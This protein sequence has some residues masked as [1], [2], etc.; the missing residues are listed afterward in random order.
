[1]L[2]EDD[3]NAAYR[4][5]FEHD[6]DDY[7]EM[8][9]QEAFHNFMNSMPGDGGPQYDEDLGQAHFMMRM[10]G[11]AAV[12]RGQTAQARAVVANAVPVPVPPV[13]N[14]FPGQGAQ[15]GQGQPAPVP[16]CVNPAPPRVNPPPV[17]PVPRINQRLNPCNGGNA[18]RGRARAARG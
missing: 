3:L 17:V 4:L 7:T 9:M 1:M 10:R 14:P 13:P 8:V 15:L 2:L 16:P 12:T 6:N 18:G 11:G 5:A